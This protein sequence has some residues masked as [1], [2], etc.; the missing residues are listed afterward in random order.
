MGESEETITG[1]YE[2][3]KEIQAGME[4]TQDVIE[5]TQQQIMQLEDTRVSAKN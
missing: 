5:E 4:F 3:L 2:Q 1:L